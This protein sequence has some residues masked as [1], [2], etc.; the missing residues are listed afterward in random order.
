MVGVEV[1]AAPLERRLRRALQQ[2]AGGV[3][4]ELGDVDP[5]DLP[6]GCRDP[7]RLWRLGEEVGKELVEQAAAAEAAR[8]PLFG[9]IELA[10]VLRFL[11]PVRTKPYPGR[12][13]RSPVSLATVLDGHLSLL[14]LGR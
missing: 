6:G 11:R 12:D 14:S 10:Q 1:E 5:V 9:E 7:P 4:E 2:L 3:A 8:H 13:C